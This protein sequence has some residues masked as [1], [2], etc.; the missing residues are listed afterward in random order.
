M[1]KIDKD[2]SQIPASLNSQKVKDAFENNKSKGFFEQGKYN[3][4]DVKIALKAIYKSKCA[5]CEKSLTD[6]YG[7]VEHYRPKGKMKSLL[8]RTDLNSN[9]KR[10]LE[11][12]QFNKSHLSDDGYFWLAFSW[13]N[14]L[15]SCKQCNMPKSTFFDIQENSRVAY[16]NES[17][18]NLHDKVKEYFLSEKPHLINP[19]FENPKPYLIFTKKAELKSRNARMKYTI[20]TCKLNRDDLFILRFPLLNNL[21]RDLD[22]HFT[23]FTKYSKSDFNARLDYFN[24]TIENFFA[25]TKKEKPFYAWRL[26][27]IENYEHFLFRKPKQ[28]NAKTYNLLIK[29]AMNQFG[30]GKHSL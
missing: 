15:W 27:I 1:I 28:P 11:T 9:I 26:F 4:G 6:Q 29:L 7:E 14:L 16:S 18:E 17:L 22:K 2:P 30:F 20:E 12:S 3:H 5:Y 10:I 13:G 21:K 23:S 8:K 19:E 25:E 24:G